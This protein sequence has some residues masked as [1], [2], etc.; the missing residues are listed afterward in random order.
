MYAIKKLLRNRLGEEAWKK[1]GQAKQEFYWKSK[2]YFCDPALIPYFEKFLDFDEGFYLDVGACDG[3]ASS[4]TYHLEKRQ[5]WSGILIEPVL[6]Q[7]FRCREL[8]SHFSNKFFCCACVPFDY[9][10]E[11][12]EMRFAGLMTLTKGTSEFNV[13]EWTLKGKRFL[14]S[15]EQL[16]DF[17]AQAR[18]LD[19]IL[20]EANAPTEIDFISIDVEGAEYSVLSGINLDKYRFKFIFIEGKAESRAV[21]HLLERGYEC[22][23]VVNNNS[24]LVDSR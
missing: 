16:V 1:L 24:V 14:G 4:N 18:T 5:N 19:S 15:S 22:L 10:K 9:K 11:V 23:D 13:D 8:R 12:I 20:N 7:Y 6:H 3:R 17:Y 21:K 2:R